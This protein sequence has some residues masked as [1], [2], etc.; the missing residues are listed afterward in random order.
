VSEG[1]QE[2]SEEESNEESN[3]ESD[4]DREDRRERTLITLMTPICARASACSCV[5][6]RFVAGLL[7]F[8][9]V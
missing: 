7:G 3:E 1:E 4:E 5:C 6:D 8:I 2:E 9:Q